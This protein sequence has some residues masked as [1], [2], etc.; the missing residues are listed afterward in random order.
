MSY[1]H[2]TLY[3]CIFFFYFLCYL[4]C[5]RHRLS[6]S[7]DYLCPRQNV[8]KEKEKKNPPHHSR[9]ALLFNSNDKIFTVFLCFSFM[10]LLLLLLLLSCIFRVFFTRFPT[11][12][13]WILNM[14]F[15]SSPRTTKMPFKLNRID[16]CWLPLLLLLLHVHVNDRQFMYRKYAREKKIVYFFSF[17]NVYVYKL[18]IRLMHQPLLRQAS[19]C[20]VWAE[21][22]IYYWSSKQRQHQ[23]QQQQK[24]KRGVK[25][26]NSLLD[27]PNER[28]ASTLVKWK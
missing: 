14:L 21:M 11:D 19:K 17:I 23:Q 22:E 13:K 5:C 1:L 10:L 26:I 18:Y 24:K 8:E 25:G 12:D 28:N 3:F 16:H 27:I 4:L 9:F 6:R 15:F 7:K 20:N 2:H